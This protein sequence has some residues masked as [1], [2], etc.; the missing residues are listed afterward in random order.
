MTE[1]NSVIDELGALSEKNSIL[2][3][4]EENN[5]LF[6][7]EEMN[8]PVISEDSTSTTAQE[9]IHERNAR[10]TQPLSLRTAHASN[11]VEPKKRTRNNFQGKKRNIDACDNTIATILT[12]FVEC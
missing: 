3:I 7:S 12:H 9:S 8:A 10:P 11:G 4:S 6:I 5:I 2:V 1:E